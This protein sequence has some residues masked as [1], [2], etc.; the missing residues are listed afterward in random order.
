MKIIGLDPGTATTG[1]AFFDYTEDKLEL[2]EYSCITTSPNSKMQDR[3]HSLYKELK[4][5]LKKYKPTYMVIERLFFNTNAKT[6]ISVGQARGIPMLLASEFDIEIYEYTAL[7]AKALLAGYGRAT[8]KQM[9]KAVA[10]RLK[11]D[12]IIKS[13]DANDAV[14]MVLYFIEKDLKDVLDN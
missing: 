1:Y 12:E 10:E 2:L 8:K 4:P 3:L 5:L 11:L 6:A 13:D 7:Q 14:A 9:Q